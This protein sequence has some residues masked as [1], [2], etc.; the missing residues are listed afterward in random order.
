[1][2][3]NNDGPK[4]T[5]YHGELRAMGEVDVVVKSDILP[6]KKKKGE[7]YVIL[8]IAGSDRY[9]HPE[10][11]ACLEFWRGL[12]GRTVRVRADGQRDEATIDMVD[13][14]KEPD[15][16]MADDGREPEPP[17]QRQQQ[18]PAQRERAQQHQGDPDPVGEAKRFVARNLSVTKIAL[19]AHATL[20]IDYEQEHG[21]PLAPEMHGP[22]LASLLYGASSAG[23]VQHLPCD[24]DYHTLTRRSK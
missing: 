19:K 7:H 2:Q 1:M 5:L 3:Q 21:V 12:K 10:N 4:K 15:P 6:S 23:I 20:L 16:S 9:L 24:L 14:G 18:A 22:V 17:L 11:E 8:T 13:G